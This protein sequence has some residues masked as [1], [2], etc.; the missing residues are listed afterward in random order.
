MNFIQVDPMYPRFAQSSS[1]TNCHG[2][3]L[4]SLAGDASGLGCAPRGHDFLF[5]FDDYRQHR[6]TLARAEREQQGGRRLHRR[7]HASPQLRSGLR[8]HSNKGS[9]LPGQVPHQGDL[10]ALDRARAL[11]PG[12]LALA[13]I[14]QNLNQNILGLMVYQ[15]SSKYFR[16][17]IKRLVI[18]PPYLPRKKRSRQLVL[19]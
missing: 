12:V 13:S 1:T 3:L 19:L 16:F 5:S 9:T 8:S 15:I 2:G 18:W 17:G 4:S 10:F 14:F 6:D 7:P 11:R